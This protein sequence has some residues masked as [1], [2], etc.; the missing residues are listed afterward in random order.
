MGITGFS[1]GL[2]RVLRILG[3]REFF[4]LVGFRRDAA[5]NGFVRVAAVGLTEGERD[6]KVAQPGAAI[7]HVERR[8][9]LR[10]LDWA[11]T[12]C[13]MVTGDEGV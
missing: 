7:A 13:F 9:Q 4:L 10:E 12:H 11:K 8:I 6:E 3:R 2:V 5:T 1:E